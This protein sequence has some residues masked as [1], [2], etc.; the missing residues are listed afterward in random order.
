[1]GLIIALGV[2]LVIYFGAAI[3]YMNHFYYGSVV[4]CISASGKTVEEVKSEV[5]AQLKDY[6]LSLKERGGKTEQIKAVDIG[7]KYDSD[8][9]VGALKDRQNGFKWISA[10]FSKEDNA[11]TLKLTYDK[12]LLKKQFDKLSCFDSKNVI[13]PKNASIKYNDNGYVIVDEVN[14][15]KINKDVL[16]AKVEN[17]IIKEETIVDMETIDCYIKP[18]Y[19]SKSE[20]LIEAKNQL[21][22]YIASK[23]T[24]NF[25]MQ[26]ETIDNSIINKWIYLDENFKVKVDEG[27]IKAYVQGLASKY[28][29]IG[30]IRSFHTSSG[31]TINVSGGD[32]GSA[33]SVDK[34]LEYLAAV[35]KEGQ[36][37][38]REPKYAQTAF[39]S[40]SNDVG[41]TYVEIDISRQHLWFYKN[42]S[43]VV[44]GN[45]VTGNL[46]SG[47]ATPSGI[48]SLKYKERDAVLKGQGY[49]APVDY[50]MPFNGGIGMHDAS[51][52]YGEFGGSIYKT[53][54]SHGCV[55]CPYDVAKTVY[56]N[57]EIGTPIV[58]YY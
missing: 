52:R 49:A 50:W 37:A 11:I 7:M 14:G 35:I 2:L 24:Y 32:Y 48:Y 12:E 9:E 33:I 43:L 1:M 10:F 51:W 34:E 28:N 5:E 21:N 27:K 20:K 44:Q 29:T 4:N 36:A 46:S 58:C 18:Q 45:V 57:I 41:N 26:K 40:G 54:G 39:A 17:A 15:T 23:I 16:Y 8:K 53:N 38:T 31:T 22:K 19:T 3:Y 30:K 42:G 6:S 55:N 25:G 13:E 56:N 47:H